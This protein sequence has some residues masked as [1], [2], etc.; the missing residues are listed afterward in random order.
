MAKKGS[1][2]LAAGGGY[3]ASTAANRAQHS[4]S[5]KPIAL[6]VFKRGRPCTVAKVTRFEHECEP[7]LA[8]VWRNQ[9]G[10][11]A[12]IS[13]PV[14]VLDYARRLGVHRFYL[15][16]DRRMRMWACDL[17]LFERGRLQADGERYV[18]LAWLQEA[19]W[20]PWAYAQDAIL[21][22]AEGPASQ[23]ALALGGGR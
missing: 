11:R 18:P 4:Y 12:A 3:G 20:R 13:L 5:T 22:E 15:R 17:S 1:R 6:Q 9:A 21:L 16:D 23:L 14:A 8:M 10:T 19:E 2:P 7:I